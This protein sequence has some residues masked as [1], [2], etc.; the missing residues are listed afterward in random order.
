MMIEVADRVIEIEVAP[1]LR[2]G[3]VRDFFERPDA[4]ALLEALLATDMAPEIVRMF[5]ADAV[6]RRRT[7]QYGVEYAYNASAKKPAPWTP[8]MQGIREQVEQV[9]GCLDGALIQLYPDGDAGIGWHRDKGKP[10]IIASLSFG[11]EREFAFGVGPARSCQEIW[12]M[13]LH[14]GSLLLIPSA[15]NN[16]LK[17]RLPTAKRVNTPRVNVTLRRFPR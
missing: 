9:A 14:H 10:E 2:V 7:V 4:D 8:L 3:Y 6:T 15:T 5:G 1:G 16:A 17:H 11:A 13:P 12:R